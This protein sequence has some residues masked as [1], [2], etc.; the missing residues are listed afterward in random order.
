MCLVDLEND[1][2]DNDEGG[3]DDGEVESQPLSFIICISSIINLPSLYFWLD[4]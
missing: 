1:D 4:S 3:E 2:D